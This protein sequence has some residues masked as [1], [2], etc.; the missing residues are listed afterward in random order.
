MS[1][2]NSAIEASVKSDTK[3]NEADIDSEI[4][5]RKANVAEALEAFKRM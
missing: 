3:I 1:D 4:K 5:K 2:L